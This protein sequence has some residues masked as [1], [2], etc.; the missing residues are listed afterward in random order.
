MSLREI[1]I[2]SANL[3]E[4]DVI[5]AKRPWTLETLAHVARYGP[6]D[7]VSRFLDDASFEYF[8]EASLV[9]DV[10]MQLENAGRPLGEVLEA[11]LY[12]AENDAF[13]E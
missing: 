4:Y 13:P 5:Y 11:L 1:L 2:N 3:S 9:Q 12:Y 7:A 6:H 10:R 8:L